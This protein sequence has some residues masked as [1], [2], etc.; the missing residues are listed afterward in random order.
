MK[1]IDYSIRARVWTWE[2]KGTWYF[3]TIKKS[4]A[5]KIRKSYIWPRRGFGSIPVNVTV[6]KTTWKTSIFPEKKGSFALP[7]KKAVRDKEK[8]KVGDTI[9]IV[10][11]I[12]E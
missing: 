5:D 11:E 8:I 2:I 1:N 6:G 4:D 7:L 9:N 3:I 12:L 10:I